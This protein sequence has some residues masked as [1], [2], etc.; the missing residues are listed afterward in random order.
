MKTGGYGFY[1]VARFEYGIPMETVG[2]WRQEPMDFVYFNPDSGSYK[3][4]SLQI[5][6]VNVAQAKKEFKGAES[7]SS[8]SEE[9]KIRILFLLSDFYR[10]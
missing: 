1:S 5:P 9:G 3:T 10:L 4:I 6:S 2:V 7:S 8:N